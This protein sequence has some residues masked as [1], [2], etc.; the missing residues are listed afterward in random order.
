MKIK[1]KY[2]NQIIKRLNDSNKWPNFINENF[3]VELNKKANQM[4]VDG[5]LEGYLASVL[6][7]QQLIEE[8]MK[9]LIDCSDF[10]IQLS[11]FP[12]EYNRNFKSIR[13]FGEMI[14]DLKN[15][16]IDDD[17]SQF[18][19]KC[20]DIN[21]LRIDVVHKLVTKTSIENI[22]DQCKKVNNLFM[23]TLGLFED[24]F[25]VYRTTFHDQSKYIDDMRELIQ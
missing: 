17:I 11:V 1:M 14:G 19:S 4:Y 21:K 12:Q 6:I 13:M 23:E 15:G 7:Y 9:V 25:D 18:I 8:M 5:T 2:H 10:Y 22:K 3:L 16:V 24:K 20:N